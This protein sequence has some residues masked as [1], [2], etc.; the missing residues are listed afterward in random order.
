MQVISVILMIGTYIPYFLVI[1]VASQLVANQTVAVSQHLGTSQLPRVPRRYITNRYNSNTIPIQSSR[2]GRGVPSAY[3]EKMGPSLFCSLINHPSSSVQLLVL[4]TRSVYL[5]A[6]I[7]IYIFS[8]AFI[9]GGFLAQLLLIS[10]ASQPWRHH[11][12]P[13]PFRPNSLYPETCQALLHFLTS[14]CKLEAAS[15]LCIILDDDRN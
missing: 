5:T 6:C 10:V 3:S 4:R 2:L 15:F 1:H 13:H 9:A 8:Y 14:I 12:F 11:F 7:H